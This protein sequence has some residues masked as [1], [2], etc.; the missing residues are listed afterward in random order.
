MDTTQ[1][2]AI[3]RCGDNPAEAKTNLSPHDVVRHIYNYD[4][5]DY[6]L[7]PVLITDR[8]DDKGNALQDARATTEDGQSVFEVLIKTSDGLWRKPWCLTFGED[9]KAAEANFLDS[10]FRAMRDFGSKGYRGWVV[11]PNEEYIEHIRWLNRL[12]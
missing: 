7:S 2:Y 3:F 10:E 4:L 5:G 1:L 11:L 8:Y 12:R 9:T 6:R